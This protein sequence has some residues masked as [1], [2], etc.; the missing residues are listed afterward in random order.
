MVLLF[1][2]V[3]GPTNARVFAHVFEKNQWCQE[4]I[5]FRRVH[6]YPGFSFVLGL[7]SWLMWWA[8]CFLD[9]MLCTRTLCLDVFAYFLETMEGDRH[10]GWERST[11]RSVSV[12]NVSFFGV[13]WFGEPLLV[14]DGVLFCKN[15]SRDT[16]VSS[17]CSQ[18][19]VW[20]GL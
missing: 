15:S 11:D 14:V 3:G 19:L 5:C 7:T 16:G 18:K 10:F 6:E 12:R 17:F 1:I 20:S 2:L 9:N 13:S 8:N 4:S